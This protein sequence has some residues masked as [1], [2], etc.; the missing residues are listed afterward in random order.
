MQKYNLGAL[1][2]DVLVIVIVRISVS[3]LSP[4]WLV[5]R[6]K[7]SYAMVIVSVRI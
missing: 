4:D 2:P 6:L 7:F 5:T 3:L 1:L